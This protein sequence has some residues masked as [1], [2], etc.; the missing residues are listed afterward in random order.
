MR[1]IC[2]WKHNLTQKGGRSLP[3]FLSRTQVIFSNFAT[4]QPALEATYRGM[5]SELV[6]GSLPSIEDIGDSLKTI[7]GH[8][9]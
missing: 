7:Q 1:L 4:W 2:L 5:F 8:L 6:Y 3:L 9:K